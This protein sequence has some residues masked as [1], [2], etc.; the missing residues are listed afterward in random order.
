MAA[1]AA[2]LAMEVDAPVIERAIAGFHSLPHRIELVHEKNG[3]R[4]IDDS[5]GTNVGAVVEA[6]AAVDG[7]V[8]LIAGGMDKGGHYAPLVAPLR[9]KVRRL[10]LIGAARARMNAGLTGATEITCV[11]TLKEA[12]A[13]AAAMARPG[14]TVMLSPAC[15]SFDQF[16]DY[17]ERGNLFKELVRAL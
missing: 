10:I 3:I 7:P 15:S 5:K 6:L 12:V 4:Y 14:E 17:A 11:E 2:A 16:R 8:I 13:M 9:E 1:A